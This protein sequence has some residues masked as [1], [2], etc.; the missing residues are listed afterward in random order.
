MRDVFPVH[1][2]SLFV[3]DLI[4]VYEIRSYDGIYST[5]WRFLTIKQIGHKYYSKI[6]NIYIPTLAKR[7]M[8]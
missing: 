1:G 7:T 6:V 2:L 4:Y 8:S 5:A 3:Y